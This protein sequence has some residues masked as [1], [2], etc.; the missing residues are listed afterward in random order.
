M[1]KKRCYLIEGKRPIV[2]LRAMIESGGRDFHAHS[3]VV[4]R[5]IASKVSFEE[6]L[7]VA[8]NYSTG[9]RS[10]TLQ[11]LSAGYRIVASEM[12][13][14]LAR[15]GFLSKRSTGNGVFYTPTRMASLMIKM[16]K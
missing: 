5:A 4:Q 16:K 7:R 2:V 9:T 15:R 1:Q 11:K 6:A 12:L 13:Y 10:G 8:R 3:E 14:H